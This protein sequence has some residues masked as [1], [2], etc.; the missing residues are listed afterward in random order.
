M[1]ADGD[2]ARLALWKRRTN[3]P[4]PTEGAPATRD[5]PAGRERHTFRVKARRPRTRD[6][7]GRRILG[8]GAKIQPILSHFFPPR[9]QTQGR[10]IWF[11]R[12]PQHRRRSNICALS[13][14]KCPGVLAR[15]SASV[16]VLPIAR[17]WREEA[18]LALARSGR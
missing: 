8:C 16:F 1:G 12:F 2:G 11:W 13:I 14:Y 4:P 17:G 15:R 10:L 6:L 5:E 3:T 18:V 9:L 7:S